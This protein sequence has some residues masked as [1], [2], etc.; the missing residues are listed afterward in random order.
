VVTGTAAASALQFSPLAQAEHG[1]GRA[2]SSGV[3][4]GGVMTGTIS[5]VR[6]ALSS[7]GEQMYSDC[8]ATRTIALGI[9][10][11]AYSQPSFIITVKWLAG[12]LV[13]ASRQ[14]SAIRNLDKARLLALRI[15]RNRSFHWP[16]FRSKRKSTLRLSRQ[17]CVHVVV[18]ARED[19][20]HV[21]VRHRALI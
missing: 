16:Q 15:S 9:P 13:N 11:T 1:P 7:V 8:L 19:R 6:T 2:E 3:A 20:A 10:R 14:M 18:Y 5:L 4:I 21:V 12:K 17:S